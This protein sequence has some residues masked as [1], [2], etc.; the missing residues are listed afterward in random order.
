LFVVHSMVVLRFRLRCIH[1]P[2]SFYYCYTILCFSLFYRFYRFLH[3]PTYTFTIH[4][5]GGRSRFPYS[6]TYYTTSHTSHHTSHPAGRSFPCL[7][8]PA[9]LESHTHLFLFSRSY[10]HLLPAGAGP[11]VCSACHLEVAACCLFCLP[12]C[13]VRSGTSACC[14]TCTCWRLEVHHCTCLHLC[15]CSLTLPLLQP[16]VHYRSTG[17]R[18]L[19]AGRCLP[20]AFHLPVLLGILPP[21]F[22][23]TSGD[24]TG[25]HLITCVS[26]FLGLEPGLGYLPAVPPV[27]L[28][29]LK[30]HSTTAY[31]FYHF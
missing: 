20:P 9:Y 3:V 5:G 6:T 28:F 24:T 11:G 8:I 27:H 7:Y 16:F 30:F 22:L 4:V 18:C 26:A 31:H 21:A 14:C 10:P 17:V 13:T 12:P 15:T 23:S 19:G 29:Y 25:V 1:I 2:R